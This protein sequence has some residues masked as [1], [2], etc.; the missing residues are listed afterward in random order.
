M[1]SSKKLTGTVSLNC[2]L[3]VTLARYYNLVDIVSL[4]N[5]TW[6]AIQIS[7]HTFIDGVATDVVINKNA[8][9]LLN[10]CNKLRINGLYFNNEIKKIMEVACSDVNLMNVLFKSP[11][12]NV[13]VTAVKLLI[14]DDNEYKQKIQTHARDI[15]YVL[16][17]PERRP[18]NRPRSMQLL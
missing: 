3:N 13:F 18:K 1:A 15:Y 14:P 12:A 10:R 2:A 8:K 16:R 9:S 11:S 17:K 7:K 4:L 6:D 5:G